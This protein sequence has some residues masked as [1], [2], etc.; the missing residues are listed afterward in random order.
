MVAKNY[1]RMYDPQKS[2]F[3]PT[4]IHTYTLYI[5]VGKKMYDSSLIAL[6]VYG[7]GWLVSPDW[8]EELC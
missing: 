1:L 7:F 6:G 3:S 4:Q 8:L 5:C 2:S